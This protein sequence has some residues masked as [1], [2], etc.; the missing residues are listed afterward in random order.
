VLANNRYD[1]ISNPKITTV[2]TTTTAPTARLPTTKN[3]EN[4][5]ILSSFYS[6]V[7]TFWR[8][9]KVDLY[10]MLTCYHSLTHSQYFV[11]KLEGKR[12]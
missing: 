6:R 8:N 5:L 9:Y 12:F 4:K 2:T 11:N 1:L 10:K 7:L 3:V